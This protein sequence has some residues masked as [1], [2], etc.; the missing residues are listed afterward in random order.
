MR[1]YP[2]RAITVTTKEVGRYRTITS[3]GEFLAHE[4]PTE[5]GPTH[6]KAHIACLDVAESAVGISA[7]RDAF[8]DAV[9]ESD[10]YV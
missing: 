2:F 7:A 1:K 4:W 3:V 9:K 5:K 8:I 10:I 6:L